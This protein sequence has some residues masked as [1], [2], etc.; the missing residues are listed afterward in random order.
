MED[1]VLQI[2]IPAI[3]GA[4]VLAFGLLR[5]IFKKSIIFT[6][7]VLFLICADLIA[8]LAFFVGHSGLQHLYWS[9]PLAI[10]ILFTTYYLLIQILQLP[11]QKMIEN[12]DEISKGNL[13]A[14]INNSLYSREDELGQIINSVTDLKAR[15]VNVLKEIIDSSKQLSV[16]SMDLSSTAEQFSQGANEQAASVEEILA[17]M[18]EMAS[19]ISQ[20]A[21]NS[22]S[23]QKI[24]E[25]SS[26]GMKKGFDAVKQ[27]ELKMVNISKEITIINDIAFQTNILALNA[28]VEAARAGEHGKGF[29]V[30]AAEVRKLAENSRI[31]SQKIQ[32]LSNEGVN[33]II[34]TASIFEKTVP[35][36]EKSLSLV[37]EITA[38]TAEQNSGS[39]QISKGISQLNVVTQQNA[40]GSE[41]M[42]GKANELSQLSANLMEAVNYFKI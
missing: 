38:A 29:A 22:H 10:I 24:T 42:A 3:F 19:N 12:I 25:N 31:A 32:V 15:L 16:T 37:Q 35:E 23:T 8:A 34:E 7:G 6:V 41:M 40:A 4:A 20:T 5:L 2:G 13:T 30:V 1:N 11:L 14:K 26:I 18:E 33:S 21:E 17:S 39:E 36:M 27:S 28:A 9:I